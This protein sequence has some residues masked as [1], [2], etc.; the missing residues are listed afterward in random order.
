M[1]PD[2]AREVCAIDQVEDLRKATGNDYHKA[3]QACG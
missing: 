1:L 3:S 2:G